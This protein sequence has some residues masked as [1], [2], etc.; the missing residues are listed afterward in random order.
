MLFYTVACTIQNHK[1]MR[2]LNQ[3]VVG[4]M[5]MGNIVPRARI[6]H[7]SLAFR[8]SVLTITP[9]RL[10]WCHHYTHNCLSMW[11]FASEVSADYYKSMILKVALCALQYRNLIFV[12]NS[13]AL[14]YEQAQRAYSNRSISVSLL[15]LSDWRQQTAPREMKTTHTRKL[16][17]LLNHLVPNRHSILVTAPVLR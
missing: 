14:N 17:R 9:H 8:A 2:H 12:L 15:W 6:E 5:K 13:S 11:L 4:V 3:S 7:T 1:F 16:R 10:P